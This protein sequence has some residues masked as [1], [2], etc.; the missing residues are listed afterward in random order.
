MQIVIA[1]AYA[2]N[3]CSSFRK[4]ETYLAVKK[5]MEEAHDEVGLPLKATWTSEQTEE[6]VVKRLGL[7][8]T[9]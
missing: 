7:E 3:Y 4:K 9:E 1:K 6:G 2:V 5:D 8:D